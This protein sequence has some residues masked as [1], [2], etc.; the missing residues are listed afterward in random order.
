LK[1][2]KKENVENKEFIYINLHLKRW[3]KNGIHSLQKRGDARGSADI[4]YI[5]R[6]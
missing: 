3:F 6:M 4:I 2:R 5:W 1:T